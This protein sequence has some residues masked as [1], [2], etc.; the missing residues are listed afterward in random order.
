MMNRQRM[1]FQLTP[2]LDLLLIVI[3]AQYMEVRDQAKSAQAK[4]DTERGSL[5]KQYYDRMV[6]LERQFAAKTKN[7]EAT[8]SRYSQH[9]ESIVKQHQ[10][11]GSALA[12]ALNLPGTLM[13][14]VLRLKSDGNLADAKNLETAVERMQEQISGRG[15]EMLQFILRY[16]E[17]QKHVSVWE[18]HLDDNGQVLFSDG[19]DAKTIVFQTTDEFTS[20][21]FE[22]SKA[23]AEPK[24]LVI[25]LFTYG[26]TQ[27]GLRRKA[28]DGLPSLIERL[29]KDSGNT[30]WF[31]FSLMW[32]TVSQ[33]IAD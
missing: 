23:F 4:L 1:T 17:M 32:A 7:L 26:D 8:R 20:R 6:K 12:A 33:F 21:C 25:V 28:T 29:R 2:L 15:T 18:V 24:P 5:E 10:Q 16:D 11:A 19:D 14:Q 27:A 9:Y 13:E 3:F 30:R 31:D 22:S